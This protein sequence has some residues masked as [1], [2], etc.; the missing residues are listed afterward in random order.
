MEIRRRCVSSGPSRSKDRRRGNG[1]VP[2][3][4]FSVFFLTG[5]RT[6]APA[7]GGAPGGPR[8]AVP[9]P[10]ADRARRAG[11]GPGPSGALLPALPLPSA[12]RGPR[13]AWPP[14]RRDGRGDRGQRL[15]CA[16]LAGALEL[17]LDGARLELLTSAGAGG[18]LDCRRGLR[19]AGALPLCRHR[20]PA[21]GRCWKGNLTACL[22]LCPYS[23]LQIAASRRLV[24]LFADELGHVS[25]WRAIMAGSLAGMVATIVTYP[26][27]VIKT[28][29]IVQNRLEPSYEGI[30]H[31]FYKIYRQE[32][33][34]ALYR[35]VSPAILGAVPFSAGSFFV[36]ISLDKIWQEPIVRF[37]PL[38][39]FI[40]GCVAAGVAQTLSF[41][42]ETVKRKMQ[43]QSPWLPH[44]GGVDVHFTG[45]ADCF[46]QT[47]KNKGVLGLW[48]GLTPSLLKIVPY[49]G[50]M[51]S[52]FEFCKRVC[53]YRNGYIE[54]PLNYKLTPGVDQS[55]QPQELR[56]LK[57]FR[58]E[59]FEP[60]KSAL[61]N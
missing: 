23:A 55:L 48:N 20:G 38:Q 39:N 37:T 29:L 47:V 35:G 16:G 3:I 61:E 58:R 36:Y 49:F 5:P 43:A 33:L 15:G 25:H 17:E 14:L 59:N 18:H 19:E 45:M 31:A 46:R 28:R 26:T 13:G 7:A 51:F 12:P 57:R 30:L 24:I 1:P 41:P 60:R 27:D 50:V 11:R 8:R 32:G 53:L 56:E 22:R 4:R 40:N 6:S 2:G 52:T 34:R 44:Y 10:S 42:F 9:T 21:C 54:S